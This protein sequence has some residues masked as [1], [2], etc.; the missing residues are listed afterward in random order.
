MSLS[1]VDW[2]LDRFRQGSDRTAIVWND[3]EVTYG[4]LLQRYEAWVGRLTAAGVT[5]GCVVTVA[6]DYSP[7]S[8][9]CLLALVRMQC[10]LVPLSRESHDQHKEFLEIAETDFAVEI[11]TSDEATIH[12]LPFR[13][14]HELLEQL[15]TR[16]EAGLVLFS[17]G[18]TGKPKAILHA[19]PPILE[20]FRK[21]RH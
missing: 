7:A 10:I 2:Q 17:S 19:L 14:S 11:D 12:S 9:S 15:R 18:S 1:H 8:I 6:G 13:K 4:E 20:K 16:G 5:P 21:P 3:R